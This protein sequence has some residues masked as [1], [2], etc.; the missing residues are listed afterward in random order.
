MEKVTER[1]KASSK[2]LDSGEVSHLSED[3]PIFPF[4]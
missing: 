2:H 1:Q 3:E 4:Y